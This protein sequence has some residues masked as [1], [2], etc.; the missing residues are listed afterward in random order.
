MSIPAR[1][2]LH[3]PAPPVFNNFATMHPWLRR[4]WESLLPLY[5]GKSEVYVELTLTANAAST[6]LTDVRLSPQSV[7]VF[8]SRTANAA[9][10]FK[11]GT[12]YTTEA[13]RGNGAWTITHAN[14]AQ[15]DRVY[16][17]AIIG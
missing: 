16:S 10:E 4:L 15:T 7:L 9:A 1:E 8:D 13:N 14:N 17:V 5:K 11:N 2:F 12:M 3:A 6:T